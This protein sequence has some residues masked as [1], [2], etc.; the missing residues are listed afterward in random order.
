MGKGAELIIWIDVETSGT[1]PE[2]NELLE[3]AAV[4]TDMSGNVVG[5][6]FES[7]VNV[8]NLSEVISSSA[9]NVQTMHDK[10][11]LWNDLWSKN[12]KSISEIEN[13]LIRWVYDTVDNDA[14]LY[15]GGNSI[16]LDRN[17][18]RLNFGNFYRMISYRSI[19]VT[20]ISIAVQCN[21]DIRGFQKGNCHRALADVFDSIEEFKYYLSIFR[22]M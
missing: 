13:A 9:P 19:D 5:N 3:I 18:V 17:F 1:I 4:I 12:T 2:I 6:P 16:T 7:L 10:S 11:G 21:S 20:S 22:E 14:I 15:F 8:H